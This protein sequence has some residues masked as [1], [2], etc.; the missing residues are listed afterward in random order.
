MQLDAEAEDGN[1][2]PSNNNKTGSTTAIWFLL[3]SSVDSFTCDL[4]SDKARK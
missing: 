1:G 4:H 3:I 2:T